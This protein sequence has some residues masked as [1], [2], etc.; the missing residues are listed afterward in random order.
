MEFRRLD[1]EKKVIE[2]GLLTRF[3]IIC[4]IGLSIFSSEIYRYNF[5]INILCIIIAILIFFMSNIKKSRKDL[6]FIKYI[7]IGFFYITLLLILRLNYVVDMSN[8]LSCILINILLSY[9]ESVVLLLALILDKKNSSTFKSNV[10]FIVTIISMVIFLN[11]NNNLVNK[12]ILGPN[13]FIILNL[14]LLVAHLIYIKKSHNIKVSIEKRLLILCS[15]ITTIYNIIAYFEI[16]DFFILSYSICTI[17]LIS[18]II[19]YKLVERNL[20]SNAY[21]QAFE[22]LK[23]LQNNNKELNASLIRREKLLK[24]TKKQIAKSEKRYEE[25]IES[26]SEGILIFNNNNLSYINDDGL[27]YVFC[28]LR[29]GIINEDINYIL[30]V[31]I[32]QKF[33]E[34]EINSGFIKEV[35]IKDK[36][37]GNRVLEITLINMDFQNKIL[38]IKD[39][40]DLNEHRTIIKNVK[41]YIS[42]EKVKDEFYSNISHELRT[43]INVISSA[44]QLNKLMI[45]DGN[46]EKVVRN[47]KLIKQNCLRLIR[48]INNF[49]DTN[50]LTEGFLEANKKVYNIVDIVENVVLASNKYMLLKENILIF[51]PEEEEIYMYCDRVHIER[52]MLNILSNSLKHGEIGGKIEVSIKCLKDNIEIIVENNAKAIPE[53]KRRVIFDKFTK[54]DN[55]L[56]RPSEGSGLGLFLTKNLVELNDGKIDLKTIGE[57]GNRFIINFPYSDE[58]YVSYNDVLHEINQLEEKVD[59]EFSDIYF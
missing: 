45:S 43:P 22:G 48:T 44:L 41:K 33:N 34:E 13:L 8:K 19:M 29:G 42:S 39:I 46:I 36:S 58:K 7:G 32:G 11:L 12:H 52:I 4:I 54:L 15:I 25:M 55:S 57:D 35:K 53:D 27:D 21:E 31:L 2:R 49:I 47:N 38:L 10:V 14:I 24:D 16:K 5:N 50:K 6:G 23:E 18:F 17:K 37:N 3:F 20:L 26:I 9:F 30:E 51:D 56:A 1:K 28:K 40:T 59:I